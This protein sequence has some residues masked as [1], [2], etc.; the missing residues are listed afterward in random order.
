MISRPSPAKRALAAILLPV[1]ALLAAVTPSINADPEK[2]PAVTP[3][4][5]YRA[6]V[7]RVVDGDT[8]DARIDLGFDVSVKQR[9]RLLGVFAAERNEAAG[10]AHASAL[11]ALVPANTTVTI[12][13]QKDATDKYGRYLADIWTTSGAHVNEDMRRNIGE[14]AGK[15]IK[16]TTK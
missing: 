1:V 3:S 8:V 7:L 5:V 4:F 6:E 12:R 14:P 11:A 2:A 15:G 13:T 10:K 9:L 16:P